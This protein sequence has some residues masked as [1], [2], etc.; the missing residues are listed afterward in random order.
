MR[1]GTF[2]AATLAVILAISIL[3]ADRPFDPDW[4][5]DYSCFF[6]LAATVFAIEMRIV[7]YWK[8]IPKISLFAGIGVGGT[9][10][11]ILSP[12]LLKSRL[13]GGLALAAGAMVTWA[14]D[15]VQR[16]LTHRDRGISR[17]VRADCGE[18]IAVVPMWAIGL[19]GILGGLAVAYR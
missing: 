4:Y 18:R 13:A 6:G 11:F 5:D 16:F 8:V 12:L 14:V 7:R 19:V 3:N 1:K 15:G 9:L 10:W 17:F 2:L